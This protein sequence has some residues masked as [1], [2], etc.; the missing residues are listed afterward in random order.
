MQQ[1]YDDQVAPLLLLMMILLLP[2]MGN[3]ENE[4][5]YDFCCCYGLIQV[6]ADGWRPAEAAPWAQS[7]MMMTA[8]TKKMNAAETTM[9]SEPECGG[10]GVVGAAA[11]ASWE[12]E[13]AGLVGMAL[14][15]AAAPG[16]C[17]GD[18]DGFSLCGG[19][20]RASP[21]KQHNTARISFNSRINQTE[22]AKS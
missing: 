4:L 11:G 21:A 10:V 19:G 17:W 12:K 22:H 6:P 16:C 9:G 2:P 14:P 1:N 20:G 13:A 7:R 8:M 15:W 5:H 3:R 18:G